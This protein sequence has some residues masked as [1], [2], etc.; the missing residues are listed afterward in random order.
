MCKASVDVMADGSYQHVIPHTCGKTTNATATS[1]T[2][3]GLAGAIED[4]VDSMK[5][6]VDELALKNIILVLS[7]I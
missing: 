4:V 6:E 3:D 5:A 2:E 7:K 1:T